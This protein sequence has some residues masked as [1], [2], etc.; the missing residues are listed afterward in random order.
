MQF[1]G[2]RYGAHVVQAVTLRA[3]AALQQQCNLVGATGDHCDATIAMGDGAVWKD[4]IQHYPRLLR[5][6]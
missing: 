3:A 1:F 4:V 6:R 5:T 2:A